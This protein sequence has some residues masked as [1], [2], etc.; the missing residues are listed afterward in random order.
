MK[1]TKE[2]E[3][4]VSKVPFFVRRRVRKRV[5]E[6]A[7]RRKANQVTLEHV[8]ACKR[9]YLENME[10]EVKGH[11]LETCFGPSGCPNRAVADD[12]LVAELE[13][14][15][16]GKKLRDFLKAKV[17]GPLKMHHEFRVSISDCPNSCSR[18][19]IVDFGIIGAV[20]PRISEHSCTG[21]GA[22]VA[23]CKERAIEMDPVTDIAQLDLKKCLYCGQCVNI[24]PT[25]ALNVETQGYRIVVGGKLGRHPQLAE[26]LQGIHSKDQL[27][28]IMEKCLNHHMAHNSNGERFGEVLNR[29]GAGF[30]NNREGETK[31]LNKNEKNENG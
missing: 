9:R 31:K 29:T 25:G 30:L 8:T 17:D 4:A 13:R 3:E 16:S 15:L 23:V 2:A 20:R 7:S 26:E 18:P 22:C 12:G 19:Q 27:L 14:M 10:E 28:E 5:E 6:E 1:W 11:Q 24:C 21:C